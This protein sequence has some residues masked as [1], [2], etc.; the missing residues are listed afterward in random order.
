MV[1]WIDPARVGR[2][3]FPSWRRTGAY[4]RYALR[5]PVP[6]RVRLR[7]VGTLART[8]V[9]DDGGYLAKLLVKDALVASRMVLGRT[10][11]RRPPGQR[12]ASAS[13]H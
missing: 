10:T 8:D 9:R 12:A 7:L 1:E 11:G 4:V 5:A 6:P 13:N 2:L 3:F